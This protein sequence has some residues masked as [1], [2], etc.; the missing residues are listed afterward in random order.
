MGTLLMQR[1]LLCIGNDRRHKDSMCSL[2]GAYGASLVRWRYPILTD[3]ESVD[4]VL[5][6]LTPD[7]WR[8]W[9]LTI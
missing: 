1:R 4:S 8:A 9:V 7:K 2:Y 3:K 6:G 5:A